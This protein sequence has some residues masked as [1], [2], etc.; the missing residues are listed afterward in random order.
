MK[1]KEKNIN[2][3][4][5]IILIM[6]LIILVITSFKTGEKFYLLKHTYFDTTEAETNSEIARWYFNANIK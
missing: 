6:L 4:K 1:N 5:I 3:T 2:I